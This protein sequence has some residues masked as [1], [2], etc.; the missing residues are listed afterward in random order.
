MHTRRRT[1]L[2]FAIA[3]VSLGLLAACSDE[4]DQPVDAPANAPAEQVTPAPATPPTDTP[5]I[6]PAD[7]SPST[8]STDS[9]TTPGAS[10]TMPPPVEE[11][12]PPVDGGM[13]NADSPAGTAAPAS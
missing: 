3:A 9:T 10:N 5:A 12:S 4:P 8:P 1:P 2:A 11:T 7:T 6:P 13:P